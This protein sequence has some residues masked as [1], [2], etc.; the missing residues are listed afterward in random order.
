[1]NIKRQCGVSYVVPTES[2]QMHVRDRY[3]VL[4]PIVY[5]G[6]DSVKPLADPIELSVVDELYE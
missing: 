5:Q 2:E 6:T 1:M 3:E 4:A